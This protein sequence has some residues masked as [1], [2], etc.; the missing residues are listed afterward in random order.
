M[1]T[2]AQKQAWLAEAES[3]LHTLQMGGQESFIASAT[4]QL[5]YTPADSDKLARYVASL[6]AQVQACT[7]VVDRSVRSAIQFIP[8]D[9]VGRRRRC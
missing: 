6:R 8:T 7:G 1:A 4:K 2:C 5:R 9:D 3:A